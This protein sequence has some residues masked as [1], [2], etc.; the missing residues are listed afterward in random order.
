[1]NTGKKDLNGFFG[2]CHKTERAQASKVYLNLDQT[3]PAMC[4]GDH[5]STKRQTNPKTPIKLFRV[6]YYSI[7]EQMPVL[8]TQLDQLRVRINSHCLDHRHL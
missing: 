5:G 7:V 3:R 4:P 2:P 1:M 6:K 8:K